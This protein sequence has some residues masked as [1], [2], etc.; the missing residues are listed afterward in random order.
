MTR[1]NPEKTAHQL[2]QKARHDINEAKSWSLMFM[3]SALLY[4]AGAFVEGQQFYLIYEPMYV[5]DYDEI[6]GAKLF[7]LWFSVITTLVATGWGIHASIAWLMVRAPE[8]EEGLR[9]VLGVLVAIAAMLTP[10][11]IYATLSSN[12]TTGDDG[13]A[14]HT[15]FLLRMPIVLCAVL[16]MGTAVFGMRAALAKKKTH[17]EAQ[18]T[19][20]DTIKAD[21]NFGLA[22]EQDRT[23]PQRIKKMTKDTR[24]EVAEAVNLACQVRGDYAIERGK[25][26][27][28]VS[29]EASV[30]EALEE[31]LACFPEEIQRLVAA[32]MPPAIPYATLPSTEDLNVADREALIEHGMALKTYSTNRVFREMNKC[33]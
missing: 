28:F 29:F 8:I 11:I 22:W 7:L 21:E 10:F 17:D 27:T 15:V 18:I 25:G 12:P 30:E 3:F 14:S 33:A 2:A 4:L 1:N 31:A 23:K 32:A 9:A 20:S 6:V 26:K 19:L 16:M 5:N 24:M 13:N